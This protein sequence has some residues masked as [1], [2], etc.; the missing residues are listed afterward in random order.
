MLAVKMLHHRY[1][2]LPVL[3]SLHTCT[4]LYRVLAAAAAA[5]AFDVAECSCAASHAHK[6]TYSNALM[7]QQP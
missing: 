6:H 5:A 4:E 7:L 2:N 1:I 3:V